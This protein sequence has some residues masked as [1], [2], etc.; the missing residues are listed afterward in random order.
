MDAEPGDITVLLGKLQQ[1]DPQA[2]ERLIPL[3][4]QELRRIA[5]AHMRDE[6]A[7]HTLQPTALIHEAWMRLANQK[8]V[9][10]RDRSHFFGVASRMMRR[11]LVDYARARLAGK[12]GGGEAALN[13]D[14]VEVQ[15]DPGKLEEILAF[16]EALE[17]LRAL[18]PRQVEIV[19]M[20]YFAGMT[21][22]ETAQALGMAPRSVDRE[23][24]MARTW[25]R[26][27]LTRG[28]TKIGGGA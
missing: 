27:E 12:R 2:A 16:D 28:G 1:G 20:H 7:G 17:R 10:W 5:G 25:L 23:W 8:R 9:D 13:L 4:Y 24:A 18:D 22:E 19:E 15:A 11:V 26:R 21:V 3:V 6:R 14:W